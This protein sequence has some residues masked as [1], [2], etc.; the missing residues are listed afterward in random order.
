M[1]SNELNRRLFLQ[2]GAAF[3]GSGALRATLPGV[4][5][6]AEVAC[7]SRDEGASLS[8][9]SA[10]EARE[11]EAIAAR[12]IPTT[13]TPGA[14]EAGVIWFMDG[15]FGSLMSEHLADARAGLAALQAG[16]PERL[17]SQLDDDAQNRELAAI[18]DTPFFDLMR[19]MT[20]YGFFG[21]SD[22]GGNRD[23]AGWRLLGVDDPRHTFQAPFGYYDAAYQQGEPDGE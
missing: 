8:V 11:F 1:K 18:E 21:M 2:R 22:Y 16:I 19:T 7:T 15:A 4:I 5:A 6:L 13:D 3:A 23:D 9:L 12:I 17:F 10:A 14:V 20:I